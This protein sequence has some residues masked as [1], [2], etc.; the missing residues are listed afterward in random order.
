MCPPLSSFISR[1]I[2]GKIS[3]VNLI[4]F[5]WPEKESTEYP[6]MLSLHIPNDA[7]RDA[8]NSHV[9]LNAAVNIWMQSVYTQ[10]PAFIFLFFKKFILFVDFWLR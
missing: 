2:W 3:N 7:Q 10:G 4:L 5:Y 8:R 9:T 6:W 1:N